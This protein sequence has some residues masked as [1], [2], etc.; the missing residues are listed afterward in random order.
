VDN[1]REGRMFG[2]WNDFGRLSESDARS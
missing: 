1:S 2:D